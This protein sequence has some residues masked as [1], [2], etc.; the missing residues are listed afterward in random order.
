M[1]LQHQGFAQIG[2][3]HAGRVEV[4]Q[5]VERVLHIVFVQHPFQRGVVDDFFKA[6]GQVALFVQR[7]DEYVYAGGFLFAQRVFAHLV[8]QVA[9]EIFFVGD[10]RPN[11]FGIFAADLVAAGNGGRQTG[12]FET[13]VFRRFAP[14]Q[15]RIVL[16]PV[17]H[18]ALQFEAG[19]LQDAQRLL[20]ALVELLGL[21]EF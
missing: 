3:A 16:K 2:R 12:R 17:V 6:V 14:L 1:Q 15:Q 11:V 5:P 9:L 8:V 20:Q 7:V 4:L 10:G 19:H 13:A 21:P 18:F